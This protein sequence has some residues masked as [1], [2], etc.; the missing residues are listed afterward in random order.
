MVVFLG[1]FNYRLHSISYDEA[2][3]FVSQRCFDWLREK[4]QLRAEMKAGKVFQGMREAVIRFPPTYKFEKHQPGL[5]GYDSGEKKRIPAWCDRIIYRDNKSA[6]ATECS[7]ECPVAA[8]V[9]QYEASMKVTDS[10]H[11][12]VRCKIYA[13]IA[14]VDKS[15]KRQ[16]LGVIINSNNQVRSMLDELRQV[17]EI[18]IN[19]DN[20]LLKNQ[21][22]TALCITNKSAK[23]KAVFHIICEGQSF[24]KDDGEASDLRPRGSFGFPRWLEVTP[25]AGVIE[26][27]QVMEVSIHHRETQK[28]EEAGDSVPQS[29]W[30]SDD[31]RDKEVLLAISIQG[32]CS[33]V[34][35]SQQIRVR[36][37][38]T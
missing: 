18:S 30:I 33:V 23:D 25:T 1:D 26:P 3:D 31:S 7:L 28:M 4:D 37:G 20:A 14:H 38:K 13:N 19:T 10:D 32:S 29:W 36:S 22:T 11:K 21:E 8:S 17:P 34:S 9:I 5:G 27:E 16:E 24:F 2:R 35:R 12:P 15:A 6:T